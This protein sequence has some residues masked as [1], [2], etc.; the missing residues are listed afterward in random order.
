MKS[1]DEITEIQLDVFRE[2]ATIGAGNAATALA[3]ILNTRMNM[4]V[5]D[6]RIVPF[7]EV[8]ELMNGPENIIVGIMITMSEDLQGYIMLVLEVRNA[9]EL[10]ALLLGET[11]EPDF[12]P[13]QFEFD[14]MQLS[15]L[16]EIGNILIGSYLSAISG[17]TGLSI[18]ASIP[19]LVIDM[20]GAILS[21]PAI[22]YGE[23]G[24]GVLFME[25]EFSDDNHAMGGQ[26]FLI[27]DLKSYSVL[28]KSLGVDS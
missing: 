16:S 18:N 2:I 8:A 11:V 10:V 3:S 21:V 20:A 25:T 15:A 9:R 7:S 12:D 14:E 23:I 17:L 28:M 13:T 26:F 19:D 24:D 4:K 5:P 1:I 27:P 6:A 22:T